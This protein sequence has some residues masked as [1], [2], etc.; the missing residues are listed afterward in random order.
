MGQ[1]V[2]LLGI[3][4]SLLCAFLLLRGYVRSRQRLLLWSGMCFAGLTISNFLV[5]LDL[6][7]IPQTNLYRWRLVSAAIAMAFLLYGLIWKSE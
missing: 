2:Y 1:A 7:I 4:T 6:V 5:F 3:I